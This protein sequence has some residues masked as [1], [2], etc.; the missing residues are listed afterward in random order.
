MIGGYTDSHVLNEELTPDRPR[1]KKLRI[2]G[3]SDAEFTHQST[4]EESED[5]ELVD[6]EEL[7]AAKAQSGGRGMK[8]EKVL[9][10]TKSPAKSKIVPLKK[11]KKIPSTP[12]RSIHRAAQEKVAPK[13]TVKQSQTP[14]TPVAKKSPKASSGPALAGDAVV[15]NKKMNLD[16]NKPCKPKV[17]VTAAS[18][19]SN[20]SPTQ[21]SSSGKVSR[22][23][24]SN[25]KH[26][27]VRTVTVTPKTI[28]EQI[29]PS[30]AALSG[31]SLTSV[32]QVP[33]A[34]I[35]ET[36]HVHMTVSGEILS[37]VGPTPDEA[38]APIV[39]KTKRPSGGA[40]L[41][42]ARSD[43]ESSDY[44]SGKEDP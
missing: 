6:A 12:N 10:S 2:L 25:Q 14:R 23:Q 31:K 22:R 29:T 21:A 34:V 19:A 41:D 37:P 18:V 20:S 43:S 42:L 30:G 24:S 39:E 11:E 36:S 32:R 27:S 16:L 5:A 8:Q 9:T 28:E 4:D 1:V 40:A 44:M 33:K 7:A 17:M 35:Q 13:K 38:N 15:K 3:D 26:T